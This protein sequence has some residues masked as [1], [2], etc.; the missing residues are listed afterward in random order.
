MPTRGSQIIE[1]NLQNYYKQQEKDHHGYYFNSN[2]TDE[3][4]LLSQP[5]PDTVKIVNEKP[6]SNK[7]D[8]V[9]LGCLV[10][11]FLCFAVKNEKWG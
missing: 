3:N 7:K 9:L 10:A 1:K 8:S 2:T 6:S 5:L 11:C 4:L